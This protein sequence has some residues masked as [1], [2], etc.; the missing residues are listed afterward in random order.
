MGWDGPGWRLAGLVKQQGHD[1]KSWG[2]TRAQHVSQRKAGGKCMA[3]E[4]QA[5]DHTMVVGLK[6]GGPAASC[7]EIQASL[8]R[9]NIYPGA[10]VL[11]FCALFPPCCATPD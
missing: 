5:A 7:A 1:R 9:L 2:A 11:V 10:D 4:G 3:V 8:H 6:C